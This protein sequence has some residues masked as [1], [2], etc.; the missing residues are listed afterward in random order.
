[1]EAATKK[2]WTAVHG[3]ETLIRTAVQPLM[4]DY[5]SGDFPSN[6][7]F[8]AAVNKLGG[9][10]PGMVR[11]FKGGAKID[12]HHPEWDGATLLIRAARTGA[13]HL[14]VYC[15]SLGANIAEKDDSG[16]GVAHWI[17]FT[18]ND[19]LLQYLLSA[20]QLELTSPDAS[21][22]S[23]L[24]LA[25]YQ[26]HLGVVR[27]LLRHGVQETVSKSGFTPSQLAESRRMWHVVK[28]LTETRSGEAVQDRLSHILRPSAP[29]FSMFFVSE[30]ASSRRFRPAF[31]AIWMKRSRSGSFKRFRRPLR[32]LSGETPL[33]F[34]LRLTLGVFKPRFL[35]VELETAHLPPLRALQSHG[36]GAFGQAGRSGSQKTARLG[37][38]ET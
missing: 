10:F 25:A 8:L 3:S 11:A 23:P 16:R 29:S 32:P 13:L 34:F 4:R 6:Q 2:L 33:E 12:W 5:W 37:N 20:Y 30:E 38:L 35:G 24:H 21:G 22:D 15:L 19:Q 18:G 26:G 1:M 9:G 27:Q 17:A 31:Q 7:A 36:A 28:F 14:A